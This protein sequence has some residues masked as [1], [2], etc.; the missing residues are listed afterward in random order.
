[1]LNGK[2]ERSFI[3]QL[4]LKIRSEW[5][6]RQVEQARPSLSK[7][8]LGEKPP[9]GASGQDANIKFKIK[10]FKNFE[11]TKTI[12][13][14]ILTLKKFFFFFKGRKIMENRKKVRFKIFFFNDRITR[15]LLTLFYY[16]YF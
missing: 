12:A 2:D 11:N 14:T 3:I 4:S 16:H 5:N 9:V 10:L 1:M 7:E 8:K 13:V 15:T 6:K